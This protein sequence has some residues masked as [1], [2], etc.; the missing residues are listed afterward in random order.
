MVTV[1]IVA[2]GAGGYLVL[3]MLGAAVGAAI[4]DNELIARITSPDSSRD[5]VVFER[6]C[7]A[8]TDFTTQVSIL[9]RGQSLPPETGNAFIADRGNGAAP[10]GPRGGP[11]LEVRWLGQ[12][13]L[14]IRHDPRVRVFKTGG[15]T[16]GVRIAD[17]AVAS[18][19]V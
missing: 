7:G 13:L 14:Q 18:G 5:A 17:T 3:H 19:G 11:A 8:T 15:K 9:A 4:C 1:P 2:V 10:A 12:E 6:D 16:H